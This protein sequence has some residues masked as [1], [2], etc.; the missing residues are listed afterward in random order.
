MV[1]GRVAERVSSLWLHRLGGFGAAAATRAEV[2][3]ILEHPPTSAA[4][5]LEQTLA[6]AGLQRRLP[7]GS[8]VLVPRAAALTALSQ[9]YASRLAGLNPSVPRLADAPAA[10]AGLEIVLESIS[11]YRNGVEVYREDFPAAEPGDDP[12]TENQVV[13]SAT[14][15]LLD[16]CVWAQRGVA[17]FA[18]G[19]ICQPLSTTMR[20][21]PRR[22]RLGWFI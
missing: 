7:G 14:S 6:G 2:R 20:L 21:L 15:V 22:A 5:R 4:A 11:I 1:P 17:S 3:S 10:E 9:F 19:N 18:V 13:E 16:A 8:P 12:T